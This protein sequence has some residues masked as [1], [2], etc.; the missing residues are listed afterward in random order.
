LLS[1]PEGNREAVLVSFSC[2]VKDDIQNYLNAILVQSGFELIHLQFA[3]LV[4]ASPK[5]PTVL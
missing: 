3:L 2:V 1:I 5:K 4:V